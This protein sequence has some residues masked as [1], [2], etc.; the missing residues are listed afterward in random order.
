MPISTPPIDYQLDRPGT[1]G[2]STGPDLTILDWEDMAASP[3]TVGRI[4]VRGEPVFPG[5]LKPGGEIDKSA[6]N[7]NGWFDTGDLGY[8][9]EDGYLYITGRSKEVINRGGEI[10]SPFEV[11]NA[12]IAAAQNE[13]SQIF[14]RVTQALVFSVVHDVL[15]EVVGVVLVSPPEA[16]RVDLRQLHQALRS[17]LQQAKWPAV[18]VYMDDVPR[19]NNKVLRIK[20]G[21]RLNIPEQS[22]TTPYHER[23]WQGICPQPDA[24]LSTSIESEICKLNYRQLSKAVDSLMPS[25][26]MTHIRRSPKSGVLELFLAPELESAD[27]EKSGTLPDEYI[28]NRVKEKIPTIVD[29][30]LVPHKVIALQTTLPLD[31]NGDIDEDAL[32][33]MLDE[34]DPF[35]DSTQIK[36]TVDRVIRIFAEILDCPLSDIKAEANFFDLGGDS[37]TAGKL[38]S[39]LRT[40]FG[41]HLPIDLI[42]RDGS[43]EKLAVFIN[44]RLAS[45]SNQ[46][47]T[48]SQRPLPG[49]TKTYS[50][51]NPL[52]LFIQLIPL[53]ILYP[54]RRGAQWT[55]FIL[56]LAFTEQW[57]TSDSEV[58]RL[59]NLVV[60]LTFAKTV[61]SATAPFIGIMAKWI[62]MGRFK[63]GIYPM[64]GV[65]HTRWWLTQKTVDVCGIGLFGLSN[66]TTCWYYRLLGAKIGKDVELNGVQLGEWDLLEIGDGVVMD[67][68]LCRPFGAERNTSMYLGRIVI[69]RNVSIGIA[70]IVAPGAR[71]ADNTYIGANSSSWEIDAN[72]SNNNSTSSS[73]PSPHWAFT[74]FATTPLHVVSR[75]IKILPWLLG[76]LGLVQREPVDSKDPLRSILAW[77][78]D[79]ER[80]A[81]HYL[82][83]MFNCLL[84]P[85]FLFGFVVLVKFCLDVV[86]GKLKPSP[87]KDQSQ[88]DIWRASL[89]KKLYP[90]SSLRD[91]TALFGQ[92]YEMTSIVMRLLG[93][94]VGK[95]VYWPGTGPSI[96]DYHLLDI[97]NDVVFGSRAHLVTSDA[98]GSEMIT[99]QDRAMI[100]DRVTCLPGVTVGQDTVLGSGALTRRNKTYP[101]HGVWVGSRGGDALCLNSGSSESI[102]SET[103]SGTSTPGSLKPHKSPV[104]VRWET[105]PRKTLGSRNIRRQTYPA[106]RTYA[107]DNDMSWSTLEKE[108]DI[109]NHTVTPREIIVRLSNLPPKPEIKTTEKMSPFGRAFYMK[110]APYRVLGPSAIFAYSAFIS[111]FVSVYWNSPFIVS[112]QILNKYLGGISFQDNDTYINPFILFLLFSLFISLFITVQSLIALLI[113]ITAKWILIGQRQPGDHS[114]DR[115]S[116]CQRWQIFLAI[117][118]LR[119]QCFRGNGIIGMLT[120]TH[121][122]VMYFRALGGTI[123]R[124]CAIFANGRPSLLFTEP[125]LLTLGDRV[126][127]DDASL[128]GHINSRG[129]FELN[130]LNVGDRCVLRSGSRLLSGAQMLSDSCLLEHTLVMGGEIIG[131]NMTMQG[132][133]AEIFTGAR[134]NDS[135][136]EKVLV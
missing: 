8:L 32:D 29:G 114:W 103:L 135:V 60:S 41:L 54:I 55:L 101:A 88:V 115:D 86:W 124:D 44:D 64:W 12:I 31:D 127:V 130:R 97:G 5:Y 25:G 76:L 122:C 68:C 81:F 77:F 63:E 65:Y 118:R 16:R 107:D 46:A 80:V 123:G 116:Y 37:L 113:I 96:G 22:D 62:I 58:G 111:V 3:G 48:D 35:S 43:P 71:I 79:R 11:E 119:R 21:S 136:D 125:D 13:T 133:P 39:V 90:G 104:R 91:L 73:I 85:A 19:K 30:Y 84:G 45:S 52:L 69:G 40:T 42:F 53:A 34:M 23:H 15:Q 100:A 102:D 112:T 20:L 72:K 110:E 74:V 10:I 33:V 49:A 131:E 105:S 67:K 98:T 66:Y 106:F 94:K 7:K 128:V 78:A 129:K 99:I 28:V 126:A 134:V 6:F 83:L 87:A 89:I 50:S 14:N 57:G 17:S 93:A 95:R 51:T 92:H 27:F 24:D 56:A 18:I 132:W 121:W 9:D 26:V 61:I 108:T 2:I 117:E 59:F 75:F 70:S 36:S 4:C 1:S 120:G 47:D 109:R 38:L 82:A